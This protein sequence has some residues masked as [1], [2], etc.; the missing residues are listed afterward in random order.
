LFG[1]QQVITADKLG[2]NPTLMAAANSSG[3]VMGK[4]IDAQSIVVASTAT[5]WYGH[6]G[7]IL[8][9][10]FFHSVVL[11]MLVGGLVMLQAYVYPFTLLQIYPA[12]P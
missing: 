1:S 9:Y 2:L 6:E 8:R 7:D 11:A 4:M 12:T 5:R 3:G 10:V